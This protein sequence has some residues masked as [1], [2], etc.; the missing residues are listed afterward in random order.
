[1]SK[2]QILTSNNPKLFELLS[3]NRDVNKVKKLTAS[4]TKHGW[5]S[6]YPMNVV[7]NGNGKF[8]IKD[9]H[10]RFEIACRLGIP[11]KYV[12]C[13][14][15]STIYE[16]DGATNKWSTI[17]TLVSYCRDGTAIS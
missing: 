5:I 2:E 12:I 11:F 17:D 13:D 6:A 8:K 1:M 3:F 15:K 10:H 16:L 14:D 4:M 7:M 9:G